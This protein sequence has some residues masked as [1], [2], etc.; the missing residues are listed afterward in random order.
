[1]NRFLWT[2][3]ICIIALWTFAQVWELRWA[4]HFTKLGPHAELWIMRQG[5]VLDWEGPGG[6]TTWDSRGGTGLFRARPL[7]WRYLLIATPRVAWG[8]FVDLPFTLLVLLPAVPLAVRKRF[9][10]RKTNAHGFM[11]VAAGSLPHKAR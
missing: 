6:G 4:L 11:V 8:W 3:F 5:V 2:G 9:A 7:D 1:M 10:R